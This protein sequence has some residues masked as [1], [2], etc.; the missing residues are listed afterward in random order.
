[1]SWITDL[2][3][4]VW[5]WAT[6]NV[7]NIANAVGTFV[8]NR[9]DNDERAALLQSQALAEQVNPSLS[10]YRTTKTKS[11]AGISTFEDIKEAGN[12]RYASFL[13]YAKA[14]LQAKKQYEAVI[15]STLYRKTGLGSRK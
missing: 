2:A 11:G 12:N 15:P 6:N 13:Y 14:H 8:N 10:K 1:M 3:S 4:G 9:I 5:N 7:D